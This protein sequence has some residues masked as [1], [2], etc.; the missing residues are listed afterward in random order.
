MEPGTAPVVGFANGR[1][2]WT[3]A[4]PVDVSRVEAEAAEDAAQAD[5]KAEA[6]DEPD[7]T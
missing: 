2:A 6:K 5:K 3:Q 4:S 1:Q 7:G